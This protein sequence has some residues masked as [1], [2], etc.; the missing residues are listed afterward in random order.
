MLGLSTKLD[1]RALGLAAMPD[2]RVIFIILIIISIVIFIIQIIIFLILIIILNLHDSSLSESA[3]NIKPKS[4]RCVSGCK[5]MS[6]KCD[7]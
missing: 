5:V 4:F 6:W 2:S 1:S 7:N 3:Y